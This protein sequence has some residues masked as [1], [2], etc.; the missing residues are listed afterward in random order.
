MLAHADGIEEGRSED[1]HTHIIGICGVAPILRGRGM[2]IL[3]AGEG[4]F[5]FM[6]DI[7]HLGQCFGLSWGFF[8]VKVYIDKDMCKSV[9]SGR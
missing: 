9:K 6:H 3:V 5:D 8:C 1:K 7:R 2:V 4:V